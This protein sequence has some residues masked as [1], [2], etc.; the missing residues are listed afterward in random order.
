VYEE[1]PPHFLVTEDRVISASTQLPMM[2]T[3]KQVEG[4]AKLNPSP[5]ECFDVSGIVQ[6]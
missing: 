5:V 3:A 2:L 1:I 4:V 6:S